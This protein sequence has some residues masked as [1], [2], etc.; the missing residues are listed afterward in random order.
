MLDFFVIIKKGKFENEI[1][2]RKTAE[3][4]DREFSSADRVT[5][6][7]FSVADIPAD[8][9][10]VVLNT[11]MPLVRIDDIKRLVGAMKRKGVRTLNFGDGDEGI[12]TAGGS[13][14]TEIVYSD[15]FSKL[16]SAKSYNIVYNTLKGRIIDGLLNRGVFIPSPETTF[17]DDTAQLAQGSVVLPFSRII[18]E[19]EIHGTVEGS[20]FENSV[21]LEDGI[22]SYSHVVG[23]RIGAHTSVGPFA[24]LRNAVVGDGCRIG[25]FVEV[26]SSSIGDGTKSAHLTYIGDAEIGKGTNVG[27]GTVFC[28]YDGKNK[29]RTT[30]GDGCFI[31]ANVNLVAPLNIGNSA[32]IAAGT[33]VSESVDDNTFTIGRTRATSKKRE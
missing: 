26:K 22:C 25:D 28:N 4:L 20:Y 13:G 7:N 27:C 9:T 3:Y 33:T 1:L 32:F 21:L 12:Y 10:V 2:G 11:D 8:K 14:K 30:V 18:G 24:R 23:S 17:I 29:H 5:V 6:E 15:V 31:G 16:G 19:C